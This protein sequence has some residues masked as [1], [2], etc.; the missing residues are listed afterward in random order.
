[1]TKFI[2]IKKQILE[3]ELRENGFLD[4]ISLEELLE[5]WAECGHAERNSRGGLYHMQ[6]INGLPEACVKI[7]I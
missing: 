6:K 7:R 3:N 4:A 2:Y 5:N 1:M